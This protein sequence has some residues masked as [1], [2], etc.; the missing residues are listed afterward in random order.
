MLQIGKSQELTVVKTVDFGVYLAE[1]EDPSAERVLL[2][3]KQVP[4]DCKKGDQ[5]QVFLYRDSS[6]RLIST[7]NT[8]A[9][10]LNELA[11]LKVVEIGKIG[12]FLDWGLEKD[13]FLPFKEQT[14]RLSVGE[15]VLVALYLDKS[16]RLCATMKIYPYLKTNPPYEIGDSVSARIY[17]ENPKYGQF[18]AVEDCYSGLIQNK[19]TQGHFRVG[20]CLTVRIVN[21]REDGKIDATPKQKVYLQMEID[22]QEI[23]AQIQRRGG[24]LPFDDHAAPE[25]IKKEFGLSK[26]AFKRAI[27]HLLKERKIQIHDGQISLK[28]EKNL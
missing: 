22:A 19:D 14:R 18:V 11:A 23:Y 16:N 4:K 10:Q 26:A 17:E 8:P 28:K 1:G 27:G 13:L 15:D 3:K 9:L 2:P 12:A 6:D 7:T 21:I 20:D 24:A 25:L 5:I